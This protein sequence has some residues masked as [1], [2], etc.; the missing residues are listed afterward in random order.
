MYDFQDDTHIIACDGKKCHEVFETHTNHWPA[1]RGRA[2]KAGW[3][4]R[5]NP[6]P[7]YLCPDCKQEEFG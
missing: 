5:I 6:S 3:F 1:A 2:V 7:L 4:M